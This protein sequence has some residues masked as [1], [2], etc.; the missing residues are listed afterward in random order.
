MLV[1]ANSL[2]LDPADG[3]NSVIEQI[4]AWVGK[5]RKYFVDPDRLANGIRELKFLDGATLRSRATVDDDERR[6]FPFHFCAQLVHG[7]PG[8]P[9]RRWVTEVGIKQE[10]EGAPLDCSVLL[11]TDEVSA[12]VTTPIQ[13]TRPRIVQRLIEN[14]SPTAETPGLSIIQLCEA[15]AAGLAYDIEH[16]SRRYPIV[17]MSCDRDGIYPV[18]PE[19]MRS[20]LMGLAQVIYIPR[21]ADTYKI[22]AIIGRRYSAY[23]GA[24]NIIFPVRKTRDASFCKTVLM[25]PE[26]I[27][28]IIEGGTAIEADVLA[29]ITHQ[30]N[31]PNSWKHISTEMVGQAILRARLRDAVRE[32]GNSEELGAYEALLQEA[33]DQLQI[34]DAEIDA[35][36]LES[37]DREADLESARAQNYGLKHALSGAQART[38]D[39]ANQ[40]AQAVTPIREAALAILIGQPK[41][42]QI[43]LLIAG[44]FPDRAVVLDSAFNS[45]KESDRAGFRHVSK[46]SELLVKLAVDYW[47]ALANG[48][49]DQHAKTTFG[50][51][52]FAAKETE[53][54]SNAGRS[55]RTF[56]YLGRDIFMEKHLKHGVKDSLAETLRIHFEWIADEKKLV[57]GHCGKHLDF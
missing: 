38:D 57:I 56:S 49:G 9:G 5:Q 24:I 45:V 50:Q 15:N 47:E 12:R 31:L 43:L 42:E 7:Q 6:T 29:T 33:A 40:A 41:L 11:R 20:V 26:E 18:E 48:Q 16:E 51:N 10:N 36:R 28:E 23:G 19:R 13:V 22:Q 25:L 34:K 2:V 27:G 53:S 39:G 44:L 32:A 55:R 54:L 4:A 37:Q 8:V 3:P 1:Y 35:L 52:S 17:L 21:D 30:T 46:A 14:C